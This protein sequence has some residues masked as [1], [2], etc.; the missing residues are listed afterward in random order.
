MT[1]LQVFETSFTVIN[2]HI[3]EYSQPNDHVQLAYEM[4]DSWAPAF[5]ML[6]LS[7]KEHT[8][9]TSLSIFSLKKSQTMLVAR[10]TF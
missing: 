10:T 7:V 4:N 8:E 5:H 1:T 6:I 3:Q 9:T 2:S